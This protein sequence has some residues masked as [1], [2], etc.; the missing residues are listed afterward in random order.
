MISNASPLI[1][2]NELL[3]MVQP[4]Q[5][6]REDFKSRRMGTSALADLCRAG[7]PGRSRHYHGLHLCRRTTDNDAIHTSA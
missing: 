5:A 3:D 6:V 1:T 7:L 4:P 2:Y